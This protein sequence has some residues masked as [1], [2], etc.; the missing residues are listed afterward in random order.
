MEGRRVEEN[1]GEESVKKRRG[2]VRARVRRGGR[3][4][5]ENREEL[6]RVEESKGEWRRIEESA[7]ECWRREGQKKGQERGG[8]N[9]RGG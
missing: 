1:T 5:K 2:E 6:K 9:L 8:E 4:G 3:G 7:G